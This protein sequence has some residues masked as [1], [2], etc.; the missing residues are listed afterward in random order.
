[1]TLIIRVFLGFVSACLA[2][3]MWVS[4][5]G[6]IP[7]FMIHPLQPSDEIGTFE[8]LQRGLAEQVEAPDNEFE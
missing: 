2:L 3:A 7:G 1:M 6:Q 8:G 4:G 5:G